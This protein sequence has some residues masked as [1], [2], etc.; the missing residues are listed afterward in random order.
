MILEQPTKIVTPPLSTNNQRAWIR[1][2]FG[3]TSDDLL[4]EVDEDSL[5]TYCRYL[6]SHLRFPVQATWVMTFDSGEST[7]KVSI[8]ALRGSHDEPRIDD[9]KA[10]IC[11]TT[12]VY[13]PLAEMERVKGKLNRQRIED[14][15]YWFRKYW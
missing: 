13:L 12:N 8:L 5:C 3:L 4:P 9:W 11:E 2:V 7:E 6:A 15:I 1:A 10:I 14:C